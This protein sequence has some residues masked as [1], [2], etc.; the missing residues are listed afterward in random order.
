MRS[1][2]KRTSAIFT[3]TFLACTCLQLA[4]HSKD[5]STFWSQHTT[6]HFSLSA[7]EYSLQ[8]R[9]M[10][11]VRS[12][13]DQ[14]LFELVLQQ[15]WHTTMARLPAC[16]AAR[17]RHLM[18]RCHQRCRFLKHSALLPAWKLLQDYSK[19]HSPLLQCAHSSNHLR[20]FQTLTSMHL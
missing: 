12:R 14:T 1:C 6:S 9:S 2:L 11:S 15:A 13:R 3:Q 20:T 5:R 4:C 16:L 19:F 8:H 10:R 18:A 17:N 7:K